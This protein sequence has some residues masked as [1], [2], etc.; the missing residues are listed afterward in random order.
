MLMMSVLLAAVDK[1]RTLLAN[2]MVL[3][4]VLLPVA[5]CVMIKVIF[6]PLTMLVMVSIVMLPVAVMVWIDPNVILGVMV[7]AT[8]PNA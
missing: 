7:V 8:L 1:V 5:S 6:C 4:K 3:L 2:F